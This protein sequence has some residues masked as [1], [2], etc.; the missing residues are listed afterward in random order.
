MLKSSPQ[1]DITVGEAAA[2]TGVTT[3][4]LLFYEKVGLINAARTG[5]GQRRY[6]RDVLR[7]VAFIRGAQAI[8]MKLS[9]IKKAI[10]HLPVDR[11]PTKEEW[12]ELSELW[13]PR[14]DMKVAVLLAIRDKLDNCIGCGCQTLDS[15]AI[16]NPDDA[17]ASQGPGSKL[18]PTQT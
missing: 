15:C 18:T 2:R 4:A 5:G 14:L 13:R 6:H 9:E 3:S 16:F 8:G 1:A 7:R 10:G 11:A 17:A 12:H